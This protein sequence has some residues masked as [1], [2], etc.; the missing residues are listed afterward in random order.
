MV[1]SATAT[2]CMSQVGE[3]VKWALCFDSLPVN[4]DEAGYDGESWFV[5]D[6]SFGF[7]CFLCRP[8]G[9]LV[10]KEEAGPQV[11]DQPFIP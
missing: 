11:M 7:D 1:S 4:K 5:S 10:N 6:L 8:V 3:D 9:V 2:A